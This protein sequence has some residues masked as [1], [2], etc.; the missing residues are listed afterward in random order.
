MAIASKF[1]LKQVLDGNQ[2]QKE[3]TSVLSQARANIAMDV[4]NK[5]SSA[6]LIKYETFLNGIFYPPGVSSIS[7]DYLSNILVNAHEEELVKIFENFDFENNTSGY[8]LAK[9][10]VSEETLSKAMESASKSLQL[11]VKKIE[12]LNPM[13]DRSKLDSIIAEV[14]LLL[15]QAE[16]FKNTAETSYFGKKFITSKDAVVIVNQ[17]ISFSKALSSANGPSLSEMGV[18]FEKALSLTNVVDNMANDV[19]DETIRDLA[20]QF[21]FGSEPISRGV[22]SGSVSY[23]ISTD[24]PNSV[25]ESNSFT[26]SGN[27]ATF[28]YTYNPN[29]EK[30]GK[31]DVQLTYGDIGMEN[32]RASAKRWTKGHGD[33][34]ETSIDAGITR[35]AGQSVAEAY[36]FAILTPSKDWANGEVPTFSAVSMAHDFARLAIKSDIAMGLNQGVTQSGAGYA[37]ILIVDTG[38]A[39]KVRDLATI[40]NIGKLNKYDELAISNMANTAYKA[41]A[42]VKTGRSESYLG[43]TTSTLNKMKV[44]MHWNV[45]ARKS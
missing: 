17:L 29:V 5:R 43:L 7:S 14:N 40:V 10:A 41:L 6:D 26:I 13:L 36:K 21:H 37:N 25:S 18:L 3:L 24:I 27:N 11:L 4:V 34:G 12:N 35:A 32:F 16:S 33:L 20:S 15:K 44:S 42:N 2:G 28:T 19:I 30:Q 38:S 31:M 1:N 8:H 45:N 22:G 39:I 23:N 9:K